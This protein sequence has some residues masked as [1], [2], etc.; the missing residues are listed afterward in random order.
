MLE[1]STSVASIFAMVVGVEASMSCPIVI[2][3]IRQC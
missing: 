3:G 1:E 2:V